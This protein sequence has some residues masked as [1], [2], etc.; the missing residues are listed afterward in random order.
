MSKTRHFSGAMVSLLVAALVGCQGPGSTPTSLEAPAE[1][2]RQVSWTAVEL[3]FV[4]VG[5]Y[6][7]Q[8]T[9]AAPTQATQT[10]Q[11][12]ATQAVSRAQWFNGERHRT[13][14][15]S[16][17]WGSVPLGYGYAAGGPLPFISQ[18]LGGRGTSLYYYDPLR[19][20]VYQTPALDRLGVVDAALSGGGRFVSFIDRSGQIGIYDM[21]THLIQTFPELSYYGRGRGIGRYGLLNVRGARGYGGAYGYAQPF[22]ADAYGNLTYL[23]DL[24]RVRVFDPRTH[25]EFIVPGATRGLTDVYGLSVSPDGRYV[26]VA[27]SD[28]SGGKLYVSDLVGARQLTVPFVGSGYGGVITSSS[29]NPATGQVLYVED[30]RARM[31]DLNTGFIDNL[32]LLNPPYP[33]V[34]NVYDAQF[35]DPAGVNI[36]YTR[37]GQLQ[38]YNRA[39]GMID[40]MPI[41]NRAAAYSQ[42]AF[43][44]LF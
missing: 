4:P 43:G 13:G 19:A 20:T 38:V 7:V 21:A 14:A 44:P 1:A 5:D 39:T 29:I 17:L 33:G 11:A 2:A 23:D 41:A 16:A 37:H 6:Q 35:L 3:E 27:G 24:G 36:A 31:L 18:N 42:F 8:A 15:V 40:T 30:G 12:Q 22:A 26:T 25:Q 32:A 28:L 34:G 10:T 9:Q